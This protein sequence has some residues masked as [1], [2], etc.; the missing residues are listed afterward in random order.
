LG[1]FIIRKIEHGLDVGAE[2]QQVVVKGTDP[3]SKGIVEL[4]GGEAGGTF[5]PGMDQ[6]RY[7]FGLSEVHFA[8]Q[9][10]PFS[11]FTGLG[12]AGAGGQK[13][14]ENAEGGLGTAVALDFDGIFAGVGVRGSKNQQK[15][16]V[17]DLVGI[18]MNDLSMEESAGLACRREGRVTTKQ[19]VGE[20]IGVGA[21]NAHD[22]D[23]GLAGSG[24]DGG[25][26]VGWMGKGHVCGLIHPNRAGRNPRSGDI[27]EAEERW[28][29]CNP[30][31]EAFGCQGACWHSEGR[32]MSNDE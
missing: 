14:R 12:L 20:A 4:G 15:G 23:G 29:G 17:Q 19:A 24:R 22:G 11:E 13:G 18:W 32:A 3:A 31:P 8:V 28:M 9:K 5:G 26:G 21:R 16:I 27:P 25:D 6:I 10:G 30:L 2:G 7:G 1:Q